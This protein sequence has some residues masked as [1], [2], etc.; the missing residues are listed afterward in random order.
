MPAQ[1]NI[2]HAHLP[3]IVTTMPKPI[4][5]FLAAAIIAALPQVS[6]GQV[7]FD[8]CGAG[9]HSDQLKPGTG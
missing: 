5:A 7:A 4:L 8:S 1:D 6:S 9:G 3:T 2:N